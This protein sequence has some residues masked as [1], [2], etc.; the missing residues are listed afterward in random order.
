MDYTERH[1][2]FF[3]I[4][5]PKQSTIA[6]VNTQPPNSMMTGRRD[7]ETHKVLVFR[8]PITNVALLVDAARMQFG[9]A[10]RGPYGENYFIGSY[11]AFM[12]SMKNICA[13]AKDYR[14]V[15]RLGEGNDHFTELRI[16]QCVVNAMDRWQNRNN[17]DWCNF[18]G[19]EGPNMLK[20]CIRYTIQVGYC[21]E[22]HQGYDSALHVLTCNKNQ[23][24]LPDFLNRILN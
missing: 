14:K 20:C 15:A 16:R 22:E 24:P 9:E 11:P 19:K 10:A 6:Y 4:S 23:N 3:H 12:R 5:G 21:C 13:E 2:R 18:C 8:N 17:E 1:I 7:E